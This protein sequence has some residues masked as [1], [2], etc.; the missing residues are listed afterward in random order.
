MAT[1]KEYIN[2]LKRI[3]DANFPIAQTR[4]NNFLEGE[5]LEYFN[6]D[7]GMTCLN[8]NYLLFKEENNYEKLQDNGEYL[9]KVVR[10]FQK[11]VANGV[12]HPSKIVNRMFGVANFCKMCRILKEHHI[13]NDTD[14]QDLYNF[15]VYLTEWTMNYPEWGAHNRASIRGRGMIEASKTF[16]DKPLASRWKETGISLLSDSLGK[17]SIEDAATYHPIWLEDVVECLEEGWDS[18]P[19]KEVIVQYYLNFFTYITNPLFIPTEYGDGRSGTQWAHLVH[20]FEYGASRYQNGVYKYM[21]GKIFE[22]MASVQIP[23]N[24]QMNQASALVNA[25]LRCSETIESQEPYLG[26][27]EVLDDLVTKKIVFKNGLDEKQSTF[28]FLNYKDENE[29]GVLGRRN[30]D[31]TIVAPAEKNHHGHCDENSINLLTYKDAMLL[32]D[33]GYREKIDLKGA[34]RA[35]FY[36]NKMLIRNKIL[37]NVMDNIE[38]EPYYNKVKTEKLYFYTSQKMDISRTRIYDKKHSVQYDRTLTYLKKEN[39]FVV[40]DIIKSDKKQKLFLSNQYYTQNIETIRNGLYQTYYDKIGTD[41]L[42]QIPNPIDKKLVI[43]YPKMNDYGQFHFQEVRRSYTE[44]TIISKYLEKDFEKDE[45]YASV[46]ILIPNDNEVNHDLIDYIKVTE[47]NNGVAVSLNYQNKYYEL[48]HKYDEL[49]GL[50]QNRRPMYEFDKTKELYNKIE[51]DA[52]F[53]G[54]SDNKDEINYVFVAGSTLKFQDKPLFEIEK[55]SDF[56]Q[57]DITTKYHIGS[58]N[59]LASSYSKK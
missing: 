35:D 34:F 38:S 19:N 52:L 45:V 21:A 49:S 12:T 48:T 28:L 41:E 14:Y 9:R 13:I 37:P 11:Y 18:F 53:S 3:L 30:L 25:C 29:S 54:V 24:Y 6:V 56:Y 1:K 47:S 26:S 57:P 59:F 10:V 32:H 39:I 22:K 44:E 16:P 15:T 23:N 58:Y 8:I 31:Q 51:T 5:S 27:L 20:L 43:F 40:V 17:W 50:N 55:P 7:A 46:S 2:Y 33:G 4:I 36:H 42:I